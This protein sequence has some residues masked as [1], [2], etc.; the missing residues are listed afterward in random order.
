MDYLDL[1]V[2][3]LKGF[4]D[5]TRLEILESIKDAEKTVLQIV[6]EIHGNQSNISQHLACLKG[7]GIVTARQEGK[8]IYYSL[9]DEQVRRLL[10]MFDTVLGDVEQQVASCDKN[11]QCLCG[12]S[13]LKCLTKR[14]IISP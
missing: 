1:K 10:T 11:D 14:R 6:S 8:Y 3:F 12:K 9:R 13:E 4:A 5:R 7:C 2:K